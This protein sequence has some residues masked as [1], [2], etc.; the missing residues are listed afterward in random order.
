MKLFF[1]ILSLCFFNVVWSQS[2]SKP[3]TNKNDEKPLVIDLEDLNLE[4]EKDNVI[5]KSLEKSEVSKIYIQKSYYYGVRLLTACNTSRISP[6]NEADFSSSMYSKMN[7]DYMSI[8]CTN[9]RREFGEF[10]DMRFSETIYVPKTQTTI[11][12]FKCIYEK[13]YSTKEYRVSFNSLGKIVGIKT[14]K[15]NNEFIPNKPKPKPFATEIDQSILDS[16]DK[17]LEIE[18][19]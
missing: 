14:L 15:W 10:V 3:D 6:F 19:E 11:L 8:I 12:R 9:I 16:L 1:A 18:I 17:I 2:S 13:K 5:F 7:L 4:E